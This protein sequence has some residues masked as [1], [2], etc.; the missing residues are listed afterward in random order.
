MDYTVT[1]TAGSFNQRFVLE[2][3][4]IMQTPTDIEEVTGERVQV[5]GVRKVLIDQKMYIIKDG[6]VYDARG[7]KVK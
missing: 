1:L 7:A 6:K 5:T 2:I 4:P 3:S